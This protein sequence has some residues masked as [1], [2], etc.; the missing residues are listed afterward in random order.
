MGK[1]K[2]IDKHDMDHVFDQ[3]A[4]FLRQKHRLEVQ[5]N[6]LLVRPNQDQ[7][8]GSY[9]VRMTDSEKLKRETYSLILAES[10]ISFEII[11]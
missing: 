10:N 11:S 9:T 4:K 2:I 5:P 8:E 1:F 3:L 6:R 7:K